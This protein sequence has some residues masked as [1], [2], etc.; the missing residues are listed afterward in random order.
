MFLWCCHLRKDRCCL[1]PPESKHNMAQNAER[2]QLPCNRCQSVYALGLPAH[3]VG[4]P[5]SNTIGGGT[6]NYFLTA[7]RLEP[8][9]S[10]CE[11]QK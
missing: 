2:G 11:L 9:R 10:A 4:T 6:Q 3:L 5:N 1:V 7:P 8:G